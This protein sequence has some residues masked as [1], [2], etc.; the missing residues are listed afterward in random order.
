MSQDGTHCSRCKL[1]NGAVDARVLVIAEEEALFAAA[2]VAAHSVDTSVLAPTIV[3]H[4]FIHIYGTRARLHSKTL[5]SLPGDYLSSSL[6]FP[7]HINHV[8]CY[9]HC[10]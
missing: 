9:K 8:W 10:K 4:A 6:I 3:E 1:T 7:L 2:L 5:Y